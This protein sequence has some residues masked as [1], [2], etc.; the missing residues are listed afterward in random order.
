MLLI[1]LLFVD[2]H[3]VHI[4]LREGAQ[5]VRNS[6]TGHLETVLLEAV[7]CAIIMIYDAI[8]LQICRALASDPTIIF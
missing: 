4:L 8:I 2:Y 6:A 3:V 1:I 5:K 7:Q